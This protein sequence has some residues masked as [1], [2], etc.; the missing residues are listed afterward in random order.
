ME[1]STK[2]NGNLVRV[3]SV[4]SY[5]GFELTELNCSMP[6][7]VLNRSERSWLQNLS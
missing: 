7:S 2:G 4:L 6:R 3:R 1:I 5:P